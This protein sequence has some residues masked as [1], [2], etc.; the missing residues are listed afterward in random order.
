MTHLEIGQVTP[1]SGPVGNLLL[2]AGCVAAVLVAP[3]IGVKLAVLLLILAVA[4]AF[5]GSILI[6]ARKLRFVAV[7]SLVLFVSQALSIHIGRVVLWGS[8]TDQGLVSGAEM[9]LR[10]LVILSS[11]MLFVVLTDPDELTH[12]LIRAG[13]PYR[14]GF[15]LSLALRFV[16]F[17]SQEL[18]RV[19]EAQRLRGIVFSYRRP[20]EVRRAIY[21]T[22][23]PVLV[24]GLVRVDAVTMSMK[25]RAFGTDKR[26]T[27]SRPL[28]WT[29]ADTLFLVLSA[30]LAVVSLLARRFQWA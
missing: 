6:F 18:S 3:G 10:F 8:I 14:F 22:F 23:V 1:R 16:P 24:S 20:S 9:A 26:R 15:V 4:R 28:R 19:R 17:F 30:T 5:T 7:F 13:I 12:V 25:G 27:W 2:L 11:S 21:Y 29:G